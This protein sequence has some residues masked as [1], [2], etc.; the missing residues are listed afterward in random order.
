MKKL[1][2]H[3]KQYRKRKKEADGWDPSKV[4][5]GSGQRMR[6]KCKEGHKWEAVVSSRT[7]PFTKSGCPMCAEYGFN[8]HKSAWFYLMKRDNEQQFGITNDWK[9]RRQKH[10]LKGWKELQVIGPHD[11]QIVLETEKK[12]KEWLKVEIGLIKGTQENWY[13]SKMEVHSL[14]ELKEK[15]GIE[16]SIF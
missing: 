9:T 5:H 13:T 3:Q 6:W 8:P 12:L 16:T 14:A 4:T 15:S 11:G 10:V 2:K 7:N 1:T